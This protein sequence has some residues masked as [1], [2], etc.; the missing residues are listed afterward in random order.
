MAF[1]NIDPSTFEFRSNQPIL[2]TQSL[3]GNEQ[4]GLVEAQK[5]KLTAT[6]SNLSEADTKRLIGFVQESQGALTAFAFPLPGNIGKSSGGYTSTISHG[7][8]NEGDTSISIT[9]SIGSAVVFKKGDVIRFGDTTSKK[10]YMITE[11]FTT[12]ASGNGTI[13]FLPALRQDIDSTATTGNPLDH[14]D[15]TANVRFVGDEQ[16]YRTDPNLYGSITIEMIEV[17]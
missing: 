12:D 15:V 17:L 10:L 14:V 16:R 6:Y 1:P 11:D 8:G 9:S 5:F 7:A 2:I 3:N 4:R 13:N